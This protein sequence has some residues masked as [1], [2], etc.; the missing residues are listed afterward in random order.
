[1]LVYS[2]YR[3]INMLLFTMCVVTC[4]QTSKFKVS[5]PEG[6]SSY[7][8]YSFVLGRKIFRNEHVTT[9]IPINGLLMN[10]NQEY[11]QIILAIVYILYLYLLIY[12]FK[13]IHAVRT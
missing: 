5:D 7:V 2:L 12:V 8:T 1:M 9:H 11:A 6:K 3:I 4:T 13:T 10:F